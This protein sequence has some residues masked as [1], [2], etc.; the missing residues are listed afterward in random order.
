M[1]NPNNIHI[2][3]ILPS[4]VSLSFDQELSAHEKGRRVVDEPMIDLIEAQVPST[5]CAI[6]SGYPHTQSISQRYSPQPPKSQR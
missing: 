6:N 3:V 4:S 2:N 5:H 1:N